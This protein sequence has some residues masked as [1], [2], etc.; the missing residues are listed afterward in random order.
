MIDG[1]AGVG[2]DV[3]DRLNSDAYVDLIRTPASAQ[4]ILHRF[5]GVSLPPGNVRRSGET[6]ELPNPFGGAPLPAVGE[7]SAD[8]GLD[9]SNCAVLRFTIRAERAESIEIMAETADLDPVNFE[10]FSAVHEFVLFLDATTAQP[11]RLTFT[12]SSNPLDQERVSRESFTF[13]AS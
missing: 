4:I 6:F 10:G 13:E 5:E 1:L 7:F 3:A 12:E 9:R 8:E 11:R 2:S